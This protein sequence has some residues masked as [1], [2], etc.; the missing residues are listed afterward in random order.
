MNNKIRLTQYS[1]GAGCGCK[2]SPN[3]LD[4]IL[5]GSGA[6]NSDPRLWV[7]NASRDDAAVY[8]LDD[9]RAVVS[10]T[11]FFMPVVDD[12]F[13][14]GRIAATNAISDIYAMGADPLLAI[15]ILGWPVNVLPAEVAREEVRRQ[16]DRAAHD[17]KGR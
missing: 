16:S 13:D 17:R 2:I 4:K 7:G 5:A 6:Q 15:A 8:A 1:H 12:P 9:E 14:F 3:V 10:T 11:D